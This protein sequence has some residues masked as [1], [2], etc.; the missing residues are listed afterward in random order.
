MDFLPPH[1]LMM[2]LGFIGGLA[3]GAVSRW[4]R[5]CT[6]GAF[7]A[8]ALS[9]N[10]NRFRAWA[11]SLAVAI[12]LVQLFYVTGIARIEESL[13]L[14]TDF[15]WLGFI[16]GGLLFGYGMAM[17]G[18]CGLGALVRAGGGD[19]RALIN[20]AV[21]GIFAYLTVSGLLS[22]IRVGL[23]DTTAI[24]VSGPEGM[25]LPS[26]I[27]SLLGLPALTGGLLV[28]ATIVLA[29]I[30]W[31]LKDGTF[32]KDRRY[33]ISGPLV[34]LIIAYGFFVTGYLG[35]DPFSPQPVEGFS[36]VMPPG[37]T[38]V[39]FLTFSGAEGGFAVGLILGTPLGAFLVASARRRL[40]LESYEGGREMRRQLLGAAMMGTG[41]VLALGCTVGQGLSGMATLSAGAPL[42]FLAI[43]LGARVG[44]HTLLEQSF[45]AGLKAA[46]AR[47]G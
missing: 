14:Q 28:S 41:G 35:D 18:N 2:L 7:E 13:Y 20:V 9:G 4:V 36:Y 34:G 31:A 21:I 23:R 40:V 32:R 29:L 3:L 24:E 45:L 47:E 44:L 15:D 17:A 19:L 33:L 10:N 27:S 6:F 30:F 39:Y 38:L 26:I 5:F 1:L 11:L 37:E 8:S 12:T 43:Y 25:H 42:T 16:I 22:H 46:F